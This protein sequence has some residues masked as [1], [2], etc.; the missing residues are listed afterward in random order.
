MMSRVDKIIDLFAYCLNWLAAAGLLAAM[1]VVC[2]NVIGRCFFQSPFKGTVDVAGL[3]G[4]LII[5]GAIAYTQVTKGHIRIGLFVERF[6]ARVQHIVNSIVDMIGFALFALIS[7][8][9]VLFA[10]YTLEIGELSEVLKIPLS[11]F[12]FVVA[13]GCISLSLVLLKD[14]IKTISKVVAK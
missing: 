3:L 14:L 8:Q 13:I 4:A 12:A 10:L 11:P 2:M 6:P 7:W 9:T 5:A 1:I